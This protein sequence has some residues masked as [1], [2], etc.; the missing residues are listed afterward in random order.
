MLPGAEVEAS[1]LNHFLLKRGYSHI[2]CR[3]TEIDHA[4]HRIQG[5]FVMIDEPRV[6]TLRLSEEKHADCAS[7]MIEFFGADN[8]FIPFPAVMV[9]HRGDGF[10]NSVHAYNRILN[11]VFEDDAIN[12][13]QRCEAAIDLRIDDR[14]STFAV[15]SA[16]QTQCE[17]SIDFHVDHDGRRFDRRIDVSV[18]RFNHHLITLREVFPEL[19]SVNGGT[20]RIRQP[21]QQMFYGRMLAGQMDENGAFSANHSYYDSSDIQEYW[22]NNRPSVRL[23]PFIRPLQNCLRFYPILSPGQLAL[24]VILHGHSGQVLGRIDAGLLVSPEGRPI[25]FCVN[26]ACKTAGIDPDTL[27]AFSVEVAP[28]SGNTPTRVNHQLVYGSGQL[29]SSINMSLTNPNVFMPPRKTGLTWGQIP[30]GNMLESYLAVTTN[31]P[32][33]GASEIQLLCYDEGGRI[34]EKRLRLPA[35]A[36]AILTPDQFLPKQTLKDLDGEPKY[37]WFELRAKRPDIYAYAVTRHRG[38]GHCSGEHSF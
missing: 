28:I 19:K 18:P 17:G 7:F 23:Y 31:G 1:F 14:T 5:R 21:H 34:A 33:G 9:N 36:A 10:V 11:D 12:S 38:T 16:G 30:V 29:E 35:G 20:L 13:V 24:S 25:D 8:L 22:D 32:W 37:I 4:G 3:V 6:Y 15:L 26:D 2:G 27:S